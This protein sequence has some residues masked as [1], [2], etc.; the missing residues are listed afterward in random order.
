MRARVLVLVVCAAVAVLA[1]PAAANADAVT[2]VAACN[3]GPCGSGWYTMDVTV[4]FTVSGS[5]IKTINCPGISS[6][7]VTIGTDTAGTDVS[8]TVTLTDGTITG[9]NVTIKRDATPPTANPL[10]PSRAPDSNGWYNHAVSF[11]LTGSDATSGIASCTTTTYSGPDSASASVTGTCTDNAGN[12]SAPQTLSFRYDATPPDVSPHAARAP[13]TNGWYDHPVAVSFSG[14]DALSGIA[15]CTSST[16]SGPNS[17]SASVAGSCTDKAGNT[18]SAS[19]ALEYDSTPPTL[20]G[21]R[22]KPLDRGASLAWKESKNAVAVTVSRAA[23][24][25]PAATLY[26]GKARSEW[27]DT[28]LRNGVRYRYMV[29]ATDAV[30]YT[31]DRHVAVRPSPPLLT[32]RKGAKVHGRTTLRWRPVSKAAYYNV[33]LWHRRAKVLSVWPT[34]SRFRVRRTWTYLGRRERLAPGRYTWYVWP[35]YGPRKKHR[36][37]PMIGKSTFVAAR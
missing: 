31:V 14:S 15:S 12:V 32:P 8:C 2:I 34:R 11:S 3:G 21:L 4:A 1:L 35:G 22:A 6:P 23:G 5:N 25:K 19:F 13:D 20:T 16:Y 30:G 17:R 9:K 36:Y 28:K 7:D 10:S 29:T 26:S 24:A 18:A 37:G 27:R 33:Q